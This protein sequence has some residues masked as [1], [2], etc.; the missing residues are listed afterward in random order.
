MQM[1][2]VDVV[3]ENGWQFD[4][5]AFSILDGIDVK[6]CTVVCGAVRLCYHDLCTLPIGKSMRL[7]SSNRNL[8]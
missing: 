2:V 4:E 3:G 5:V 7:M 1:L 8:Y 6:H